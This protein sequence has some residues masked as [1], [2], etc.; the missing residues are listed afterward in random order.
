MHCN[1]VFSGQTRHCG[2]PAIPTASGRKCAVVKVRS[3][4]S[5]IEH[6]QQQ[7]HGLQDEFFLSFYHI[8]PLFLTH[9]S[10]SPFYSLPTSLGERISLALASTMIKICHLQ[11]ARHQP[12]F[13]TLSLSL[14]KTPTGGHSVPAS[15]SNLLPKTKTN[16][17]P[18]HHHHPNLNSKWIPP[19]TPPLPI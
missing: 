15:S 8:P 2:L 1:S 12:S 10:I 3:S 6:V 11:T 16:N 9:F 17:P 19:T 5:R 7:V 14:A 18:P 4:Y 13:Q